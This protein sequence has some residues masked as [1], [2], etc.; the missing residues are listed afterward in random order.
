MSR[1]TPSNTNMRIKFILG[2]LL[3]ALAVSLSGTVSAQDSTSQ[4]F[5]I[6]V[7]VAHTVT[8][9]WTASTSASTET[10]TYSV[11]RGTL[12]GGPYTLIASGISPTTFI[13][14]TVV[15]GQTYFYVVT[16]V[17]SFGNESVNSNELAAGVPL[18]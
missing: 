1:A 17:D 4:P 11:Y 9:N 5:T 14:T 2:L 18:P 6:P 13:D 10:I 8:L 7:T 16:A 3:A 12:S 15:S